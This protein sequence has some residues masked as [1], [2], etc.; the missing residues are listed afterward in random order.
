[1]LVGSFSLL[2][3]SEIAGGLA[4][5][6]YVGHGQTMNSTRKT[7]H[8]YKTWMYSEVCWKS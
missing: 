5:G 3:F 1:M 8:K 6:S 2:G 7:V 4:G